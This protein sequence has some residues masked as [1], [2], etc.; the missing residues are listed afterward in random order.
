MNRYI[1]KIVCKYCSEESRISVFL[2]AAM[3][4]WS[5]AALAT[6]MIFCLAAAKVTVPTCIANVM[7]IAIYAGI[8]FGLFGGILFL[9]RRGGRGSEKY[10]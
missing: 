10:L 5:I 3:L 4:M 6:G 7:C 1:W 2:A 9:M 8:I